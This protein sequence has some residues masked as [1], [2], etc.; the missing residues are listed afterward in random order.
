MLEKMSFLC[1]MLWIQLV[2]FGIHLCHI[3][4]RVLECLPGS[5]VAFKIAVSRV[6]EIAQFGEVLGMQAGVPEFYL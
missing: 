1:I 5:C 6:E 3:R 2:V 4:C